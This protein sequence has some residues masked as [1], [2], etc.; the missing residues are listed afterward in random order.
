MRMAGWLSCVGFR[1]VPSPY[2]FSASR[3]TTPFCRPGGLGYCKSCKQPPVF[4]ETLCVCSLYFVFGDGPKHP[5]I[6]IHQPKGRVG[7]GARCKSSVF[8]NQASWR[9]TLA[10]LFH[11]LCSKQNV[12]ISRDGRLA[13]WLFQPTWR[14]RLSALFGSPGT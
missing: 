12:Y 5:R 13:P 4:A 1:R 9:A 7:H 8:S 6:I 2:S 11:I 14:A 3:S 10:A